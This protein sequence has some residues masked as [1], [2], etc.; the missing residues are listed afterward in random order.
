MIRVLMRNGHIKAWRSHMRT[1]TGGS[2]STSQGTPGVDGSHRKREAM[3]LRGSRAN[4]DGMVIAD[5]L[6]LKL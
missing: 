2:Y 1:E 6:P 4:P 5:F 3:T